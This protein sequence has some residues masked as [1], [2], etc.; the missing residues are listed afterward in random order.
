MRA[1]RFS[2]VRVEPA[3]DLG[4]SLVA[5]VH[6]AEARKGKNSTVI[7]RADSLPRRFLIEA[8]MRSVFVAAADILGQQ[9]FQMGF[10]ECDQIV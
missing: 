1:H 4:N 3:I 2:E 8:Q 5:V 7:H 10:I 6:P 9:A